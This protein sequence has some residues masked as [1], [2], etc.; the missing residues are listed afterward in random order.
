MLSHHLML[1]I[2]KYQGFSIVF[3]FMTQSSVWL[4]A[5]LNACEASCAQRPQGLKRACRGLQLS[6]T[7][8]VGGLIPGVKINPPE[9]GIWLEHHYLIKS[10]KRQIL[11]SKCNNTF[12]PIKFE[13]CHSLTHADPSV[14]SG[15]APYDNG[16]KGDQ[17]QRRK[18]TRQPLP[19]SSPFL[20]TSC[21]TAV[22]D[23][24]PLDAVWG[25]SGSD[26]C[27]RG[28]RGCQIRLEEGRPAELSP[29]E[30]L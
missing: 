9:R 7:S 5:L 26:P 18:S 1:L 30:L 21:G 24:V 23:V 29:G 15:S 12:V 19:L 2:P 20:C 25:F 27:G 13:V 4:R 14:V 16:I 11:D 6:E 3:F 10:I 8:L 28:E 22:S 17:N